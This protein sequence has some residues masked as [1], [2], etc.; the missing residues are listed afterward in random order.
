MEGWRLVGG[1]GGCTFRTP[2]GVFHCGRLSPLNGWRSFSGWRMH[3]SHTTAVTCLCEYVH[4]WRGGCHRIGG[5]HD[6]K[7]ERERDIWSHK[8][9]PQ[10]NTGL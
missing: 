5:N 6:R 7:A 9:M 1:G 10:K 4:V 3:A 8:G 2:E